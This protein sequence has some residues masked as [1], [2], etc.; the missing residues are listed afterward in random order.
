MIRYTHIPALLLVVY[1][2]V[3]LTNSGS[4]GRARLLDCLIARSRDRSIDRSVGWCWLC[5]DSGAAAVAMKFGRQLL[6]NVVPHWRQHC[7]CC[8]LGWGVGIR[9]ASSSFFGV[10]HTALVLASL[11]LSVLR[12]AVLC[13]SSVCVDVDYYNLLSILTDIFPTYTSK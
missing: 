12:C 5:S 7:K 1:S 4:V 10:S 8:V 6:E 13:C 11:M 9:I 2:C 3:A